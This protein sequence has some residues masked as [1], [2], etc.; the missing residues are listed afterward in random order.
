MKKALLLIAAATV[1]STSAW[2]DC[3]YPR[4]PGK[5]PDG[6]TAPREELLATKK[7]VDQYNTDMTAYLSCIKT[8]HDAAVAKLGAGATEEQKQQMAAM[9]TQKNDAAV[10]ELQG[11]AERFNEQ[12]RA[13][14]AKNPAK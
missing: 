2:A 7:L 4:A 5:M 10:D 14:R 11:V 8:E 1:F 13:Y 9:Y 3:T 12:V 6:N